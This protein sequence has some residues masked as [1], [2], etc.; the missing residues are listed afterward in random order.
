MKRTYN[1]L[2]T[3][4]IASLCI[5]AAMVLLFETDILPDGVYH[6]ATGAA[7]FVWATV[8]ELLTICVIPVA[9]RLF[10]FGS[11]ARRLVSAEA[12]L[13]W[14]SLRLL[15]LCVPMVLNTLLYYMYLFL[16]A[17]ITSRA[18]SLWSACRRQSP[19]RC[20]RPWQDRRSPPAHQRGCTPASG[21]IRRLRAPFR[22]L[23]RC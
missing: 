7:E 5:S 19:S 3:I 14:G 1:V 20:T 11:I 4:F 16:A 8:M 6:T 2:N 22:C 23:R 18:P 13:S 17:L 12:L 21:R 10:R 9:L 15:M